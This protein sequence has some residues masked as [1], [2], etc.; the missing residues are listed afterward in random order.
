M[1]ELEVY[2][3]GL[4]HLDKILKLDHRAILRKLVLDPPFIGAIPAELRPK[5]TTQPLGV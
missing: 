5:T 1:L 4:G 3:A 2:P